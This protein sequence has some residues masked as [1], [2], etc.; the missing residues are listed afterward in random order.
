[1]IIALVGHEYAGKTR[2]AQYL[3]GLSKRN[4]ERLLPYSTAAEGSG[5]AH[6]VMQESEREAV[7]PDEI[8]YTETDTDGSEC[9]YLKS[10]FQADKDII[11]VVNSPAGLEHLEDF[12]IPFVVVYV[13]CTREVMN[14]RAEFVDV[15]KQ[16]LEKRAADIAESMKAFEDSGEYSWY[17]NT[18]NMS[19]ASFALS[20]SYFLQVFKG[21]MDTRKPDEV[22]M[23]VLSRIVG[24]DWRAELK[25][26]CFI[27]VDPKEKMVHM[28]SKVWYGETEG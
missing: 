3:K 6:I 9:L 28:C 22:R 12:G 7:R 13:D 14:K 19:K 4:F 1:M 11:Y 5:A 16:V 20:A 21:W 17:I 23:P 27:H 26:Y 8:F 15:D 18:A 24:K 10:Q 25:D 2:F